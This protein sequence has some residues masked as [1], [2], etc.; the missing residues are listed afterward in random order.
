MSP[1][2]LKVPRPGAPNFWIRLDLPAV[3]NGHVYTLDILKSGSDA[4][5]REWLLGEIPNLLKK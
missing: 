1:R 3:K 4:A 2:H 5:T